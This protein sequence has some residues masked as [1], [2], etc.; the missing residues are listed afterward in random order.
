LPQPRQFQSCFFVLT[1]KRSAPPQTGQGPFADAN[2]LERAEA[3]SN[4]QDV[5]LSRTFDQAKPPHGPRVK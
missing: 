2:A 5:G 1:L 4:H 3:L